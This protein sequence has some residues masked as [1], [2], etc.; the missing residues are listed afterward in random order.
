MILF[1]LTSLVF[2]ARKV[3]ISAIQLQR[4]STKTHFPLKQ[5]EDSKEEEKPSLL[6]VESK[7]IVQN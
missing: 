4:G 1:S 2:A 5:I 7:K 3:I 6:Y